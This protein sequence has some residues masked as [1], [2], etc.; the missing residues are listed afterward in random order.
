[1]CAASLSDADRESGA[2]LGHEISKLEVWAHRKNR[3]TALRADWGAAETVA[4][5]KPPT[6]P[7]EMFLISPV[8]D[9][10][11]AVDTSETPCVP[12]PSRQP[13]RAGL[14]TRRA[15]AERRTP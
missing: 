1:M 15:E 5:K 3:A 10:P 7:A 2:S 8:F 9:A 11:Q 4:A 14:V 12:T 6:V 13:P